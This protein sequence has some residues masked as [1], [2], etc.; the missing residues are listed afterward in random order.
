MIIKLLI[1]FIVFVAIIFIISRLKT[2]Y[3]DC[4]SYMEDVGVAVFGLCSGV[5][6]GSE[7]TDF[8]SEKCI[9]CPYYVGYKG[10]TKD[11]KE[12]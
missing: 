4:Y 9:D 2:E 8:V 5:I 6:G 11:E 12:N 7:E 1:L 3:D 10:E